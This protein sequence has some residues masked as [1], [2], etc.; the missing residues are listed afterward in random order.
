MEL[1]PQELAELVEQ[2]KIE[3][4]E[5]I[6]T[7][8]NEIVADIQPKIYRTAN[9]ILRDEAA[10]EDLTQE[11]LMNIWSHVHTIENN[12]AFPK[13]VNTCTVRLAIN[14]L[15]RGKAMFTNNEDL[16]AHDAM[17]VD[18]PDMF[19]YERPRLERFIGNLADIYSQ[20]IRMFYF[21]RMSTV[22]I[23]KELDTNKSSVCRRLYYGRQKLYTM[24]LA[25]DYGREIIENHCGMIPEL[26]EDYRFWED[27]L[28][29]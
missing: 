13:W 26:S 19:T 14:R 4:P 17:V 22:E 10:A 3:Q 6:D 9:R 24:I 5:G 8:F 20:V 27:S 15:N 23:A 21:D 11:V 12:R 28:N 16:E 2:L 25:D 18:D 29:N 7:A 1:G